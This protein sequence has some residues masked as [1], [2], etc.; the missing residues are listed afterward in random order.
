MAAKR[1]WEP[2]EVVDGGIAEAAGSRSG[3]GQAA[4]A[5]PLLEPGRIRSVGTSSLSPACW[6]RTTPPADLS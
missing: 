3:E 5:L 6:L 1:Q 4:F 2:C